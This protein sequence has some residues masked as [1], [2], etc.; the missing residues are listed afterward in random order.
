MAALSLIGVVLL[1]IVALSLDGATPSGL[2][3]SVLAL[4]VGLIFG[5][6]LIVG[7]WIWAKWK[8]EKDRLA[9]ERKAQFDEDRAQRVL[10]NRANE[11][12]RLRASIREHHGA[13][14]KNLHRAVVRNDYGAV[15]SDNRHGAILEFLDST[16][17]SEHLVPIDE[18]VSIIDCELSS[19]QE[20]HIES[21]FDVSS[22]PT[23]GHEFE[24]WVA[25]A[26]KSFGWSA[27]VTSGSGDQGIDV[28]ASRSGR[29]VGLQCKLYSGPVGNKAVQEAF[30]GRSYHRVEKVAVIS[31][32]RF[33]PS[34]QELAASTDV[35][36]LSH[37]DLPALY[38]KVFKK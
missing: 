10:T 36:L 14:S 16:G 27:S 24:H 19:L 34:A 32:S 35:I 22:I 2:A 28:I 38:D 5:S 13:L 33:T 17:I 8:K 25:S 1:I 26:L 15:V 11:R 6:P 37:H 7:V 30:A 18:A 20:H 29:T 3:I 12:E 4:A 31:N 9:K 23:D 21:G